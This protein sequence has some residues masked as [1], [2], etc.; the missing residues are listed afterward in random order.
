ME[1]RLFLKTPNGATLEQ[2][3]CFGLRVLNTNK[4]MKITMYL[5]SSKEDSLQV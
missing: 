4:D 3:L 1:P 5:G 2:S